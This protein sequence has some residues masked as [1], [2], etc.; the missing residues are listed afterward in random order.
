MVSDHERNGAGRVSRGSGP[1]FLMDS[2]SP[3]VSEHAGWVSRGPVRGLSRCPIMSDRIE[4]VSRAL[5]SLRS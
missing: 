1:W 4:R 3:M 5:G 2:W